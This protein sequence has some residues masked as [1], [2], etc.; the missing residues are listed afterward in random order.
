[1]TYDDR[2]SQ[3][4]G[5]IVKYLPD[6]LQQRGE[7]FPPESDRD[8]TS[9]SERWQA[10]RGSCEQLTCRTT[11]AVI[12]PHGSL[13]IANPEESSD[14]SD[15]QTYLMIPIIC[16]SNTDISKPSNVVLH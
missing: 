6:N 1:M 13:S 10:S 2:S 9:V 12:H 7:Q 3:P 15:D 4:R 16:R 14:I 5:A 11:H 8:S